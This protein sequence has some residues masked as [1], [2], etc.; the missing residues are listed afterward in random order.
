MKIVP[1]ILETDYLNVLKYINDYKTFTDEMQ[2]DV[3]DGLYVNSLTWMP[4]HFEDI[5]GY[6]LKLEFDLMMKDPLSILDILLFY[7]A[8]KIVIHIKDMNDDEF[9]DIYKKI[10]QKNPF[11][12]V[13]ICADTVDDANVTRFKKLH[14]YYDYIQFMGIKNVGH[15]GQEFNVEILKYIKIMREFLLKLDEPKVIQV[16][17]GMNME[18][19]KLCMESGANSFVVGSAIKKDAESLIDYKNNYTKIKELIS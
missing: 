14:D 16:D 4:N 13:G 7:D 2:I 12:K 18:S 11:I 5:E 1:A 19:I 6:G 8:S 15:Q 3:C 10:K 9:K 17:G